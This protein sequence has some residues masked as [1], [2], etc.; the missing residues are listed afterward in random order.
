MN[1]YQDLSVWQRAMDLAVEC[2]SLTKGFPREEVYGLVSQIRRASSSVAANIAEGYGP[3]GTGSYVQHLKIAQGSLKELET[4]LLLSTR[5]G[6]LPIEGIGA[7]TA[8][9]EETGKML[10]SLIRRLQDTRNENDD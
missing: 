6:L 3:D 9:S 1:S 2:Y 7:A 10:R 4:H 5:V 8:L